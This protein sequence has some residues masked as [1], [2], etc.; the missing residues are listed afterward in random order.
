MFILLCDFFVVLEY[1]KWIVILFLMYFEVQILVIPN[2]HEHDV[3]M[4]GKVKHVKNLGGNVE[5]M[6][7][8]CKNVVIV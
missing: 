3:L 7:M 5:C 6:H 2:N 1:D 8:K 4:N